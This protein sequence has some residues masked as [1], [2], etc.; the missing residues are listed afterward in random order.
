MICQISANGDRIGRQTT[1]RRGSN[2]DGR[3][4]C[5]VLD[6]ATRN[7]IL[8]CYFT[9]V[10]SA[11]IARRFGCSAASARRIINAARKRRIMALQLEF[12][13]SGEFDQDDAEQVI[14]S[15]M[16]ASDPVASPSI[17]RGVPA[18]L[19]SLYGTPLLSREQEFHLFRKLNFLKFKVSQLRAKLAVRHSRQLLDRIEQLYD[20]MLAVKTQIVKSNLRLVVSL[21]KRYVRR[22]GNL[23]E[24]VSDGNL[25]LMNAVDKFDYS[26]GNKLST[27]ASWAIIRNFARSIPSERRY[28]SRFRTRQEDI[29]S[30]SP[31]AHISPFNEETNHRQREI[32][33]G[34]ILHRLDAREREIV[35]RRFGLRKGQSPQKLEEIGMAFGVSKER[36]RQLLTR[37]L[38]K[39]RVAAEQERIEG[40]SLD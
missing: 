22:G 39:L 10:S 19:A 37:S 34:K 11:A 32:V 23:W 13:A 16:P 31:D 30:A 27:Y 21:A 18:Y 35:I 8:T 29:L 40:A 5:V 28:Q 7:E 17:P 2:R 3:E 24:L 12:V 4:T 36:I 1:E 26:R 15:E 33:V 6:A 25:S 38:D 9:G 20:A 14:L